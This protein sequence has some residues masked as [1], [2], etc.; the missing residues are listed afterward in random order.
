MMP[1][2]A[3]N[4]EKYFII[5]GNSELRIA[6]DNQQVLSNFGTAI[7]YYDKKDKTIVNF[8]REGQN[9]QVKFIHL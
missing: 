1:E 4:Y 8:L 9:R 2:R 7:G 6:P 5:F 3:I